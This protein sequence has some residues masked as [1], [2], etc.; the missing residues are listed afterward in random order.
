M[1][2]FSDK[3]RAFSLALALHVAFVLALVASL[4]WTHETRAVPTPGPVIEASLV[5]PTQAPK[6]QAAPRKP[7]PP[8]PKPPEPKPAPD[9]APPKPEPPKPEPPEPAAPSPAEVQRQDLVERERVA[10]LAREQAEAAKRE[11]E[12][13]QRQQQVE[14]EQERQAREARE[15]EAK[16]KELAE[17]RRQREAAERRL[18]VERERLAQLEDRNRTPPRAPTPETA[19]EAEAAQTG[20]GGRDDDLAARYQAAIQAAVTQGWNRPE[21]AQPGLRCTVRIAQIP[22]GDVISAAVGTPCNADPATRLSIEQ[23][24]MR[25]SPLPY[26]G[27]EAVFERNIRFN[28]KY[29]GQE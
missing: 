22:G 11:Q 14:L 13:R 1:E 23:A 16:Q 25:A 29:N 10:A 4:W 18:R 26:R 6:P 20:A 19:P 8:K 12:A 21:S 9:P 2:S 7:A 27:Y 17:I 5:G 15:R 3:L 28:F 24:V